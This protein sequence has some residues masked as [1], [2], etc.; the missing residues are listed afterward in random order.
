M[1]CRI[2]KLNDVEVQIGGEV[3]GGLVDIKYEIGYP[4]YESAGPDIDSPQYN[5]TVKYRP[6]IG[7]NR[8]TLHRVNGATV[9]II[10]PWKT[11]EFGRCKTRSI[12]TQTDSEGMIE[13]VCLTGFSISMS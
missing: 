5:I 9:R 6:L 11:V 1:E 13:T 12:T 4:Y 7:T 8:L 2:V 10:E 3:I